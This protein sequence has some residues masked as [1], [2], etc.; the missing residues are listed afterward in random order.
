MAI[1]AIRDDLLKLIKDP[2]AIDL[3]RQFQFNSQCVSIL[4][5]PKRIAMTAWNAMVTMA[6]S[7]KDKKLMHYLSVNTTAVQDIILDEANLVFGDMAN[8]KNQHIKHGYTIHNTVKSIMKATRHLKTA[9]AGPRK[10]AGKHVLLGRKAIGGPA[11][12]KS[13]PFQGGGLGIT[14][15]YV[16]SLDKRERDKMDKRMYTFMMKNVSKKISITTLTRYANDYNAANSIVNF[17]VSRGTPGTKSN[18]GKLHGP[19]ASKVVTGTMGG[20]KLVGSTNF[21]EDTSV[22]LV[23]IVERLKEIAVNPG[24]VKDMEKNKQYD[25]ALDDILTGLDA[26]FVINQEK[27]SNLVLNQREINV[28]MSLGDT[29]SGSQQQKEMTH[30]DAANVRKIIRLISNDLLAN[31]S[32][33]DYKAST[34]FAQDYQRIVPGKILASMIKKDG[35]PDMRFKANKKLIADSRKK[36]KKK[37]NTKAKEGMKGKHSTK[38]IT[39]AAVTAKKPKKDSNGIMGMGVAG[40]T[41]SPVAL[42]ELIQAQLSERLLDNMKLPALRNRTGRFRRSAQV[43]NVMVGPRGG[44]EV[45]YT[46]M[47]DPYSTFEP[48][49]EMGST[50]RDPRR[51]IGGTIREIAIELTGNKFIRT[52]SL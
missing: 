47:K 14:C 46:Y 51:L 20:S 37:T 36:S 33:P 44:T 12:E 30:A 34:S 28:H 15:Q 16:G 17:D 38:I 35:T 26:E 6:G 25:V 42:K 18:L 11:I 40:A 21:T 24:I 10:S 4:H 5:D 9:H 23:G 29:T 19:T 8:V 41:T 43:Q 7:R 1:K 45:Q 2:K 27:I 49:G 52:R 32:D 22:P 3:L 13:M 50:D 48:G 39:A 31:N